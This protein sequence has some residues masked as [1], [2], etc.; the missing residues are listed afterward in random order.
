ML[1]CLLRLQSKALLLQ[2]SSPLPLAVPKRPSPPPLPPSFAL[3]LRPLQLWDTSSSLMQW[4]MLKTRLQGLL[5]R[6]QL[7]PL[8]RLQRL[9]PLAAAIF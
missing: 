1:L 7:K 8:L 3:Q 4:L 5:Q 2:P 6:W 9:A